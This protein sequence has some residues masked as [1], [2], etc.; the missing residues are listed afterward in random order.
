[1]A[2][3]WRFQPRKE[4]SGVFAKHSKH[5]PGFA[6]GLPVRR[7]NLEIA[8]GVIDMKRSVHENTFIVNSIL[9][10]GQKL[11]WKGKTAFNIWINHIN[12]VI[13][14]QGKKQMDKGVTGF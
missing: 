1:V 10:L 12:M 3:S 11:Q 2:G 14:D 5:A 4:L 6:L 7:A 8:F 9:P 13:I